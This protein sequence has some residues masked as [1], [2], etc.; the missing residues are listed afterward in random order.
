MAAILW[1]RL[2]RM[3]TDVSMYVIMMVMALMLSFIFGNALFGGESVQRLGVVNNDNSQVT[4]AFLENISGYALQTTD[5]T[6]AQTAVEKG[7]TLA[8]IVIPDGF[9]ENLKEGNAALTLIQTAESADIMALKNEIVSAANS[10]AHVYSLYASLKETL[11]GTGADALSVDDVQQAYAGETGENAAVKVS[12]SVLGADAYDE[13][14]QANIHYLMGFNIFFVLFSI[15]FTIGAILE[16]KKFGTWNRIRISPVS[17][18][19]VLAGNFLPAF[20]VGAAQMA[21]V[22]FAGQLLFGID[23][24]ASAGP[25]Y[26]VF[27]V[28]AL[29]S[30]CF[31]LLIS[32]LFSTYEQLNAGTPVIIVATSMLGGCMWPLSIV[33]SDVLLGIANAMPQKW[34]LEAAESLAVSGGGIDTVSTHILILL[35]MA[36]VFF[37]ISV[38]LYNKK[39]RA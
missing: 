13:Q 38:L 10:T 23:L 1:V 28:F 27:V 37:G 25:I 24:G 30:T 11:A 12:L 29:T 15:V 21:I 17:G 4:E 7:E 39:Q 14:Y 5:E 33:G 31:G 32:T 34:A 19:A 35:G 22:L 2:K 16:D 8:A 3:R 36:L 20:L 18:T 9:G 26:L 6:K